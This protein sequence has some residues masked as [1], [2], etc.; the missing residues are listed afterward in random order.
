M[1]HISEPTSIAGQ[2]D[3]SSY[4][5]WK[6]L[7]SPLTFGLM[8]CSGVG[9]VL[10]TAIYL[11]EG[12]TRPGYDAW[13]QPIS[14]LSLG[15]GG[16]VE[17]ANFIVFGVL[18]V[19]SAVGWYRFL[20]PERAAIWFLLLQ[21]IGGLGLI[22]AGLFSMDP[23]PGYPPG[24]TLS[25]STTHGTLHT[26]CAFTIIFALAL[27]CFALAAHCARVLHWRGWAAYSGIAGVLMLVL[28]MAFIQY[29]T[30]PA[31]G[32]VERLS[33][34]SHDLWMCLLLVALF[35]Q[36]RSLHNDEKHAQEKYLPSK[37]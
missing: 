15:P 11:L 16:W 32:L 8:L 28:W 30:S 34:G 10:F 25:T 5:L 27:S 7:Q 20:T 21:S 24:T 29:P 22:G 19:L 3:L 37:S 2:S 6:G 14:A 18:L 35:F 13:Q 1:A 26:I 23:F 12:V 9:A 17:Q 31:S 36:R 33:A 4:S